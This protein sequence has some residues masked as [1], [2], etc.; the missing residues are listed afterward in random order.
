[1]STLSNVLIL[2]AP[3]LPGHYIVFVLPAKCLQVMHLWQKELA[4]LFRR[5]PNLITYQREPR[6]LMGHTHKGFRLLQES[7]DPLYTASVL[8]G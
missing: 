4:Y 8:S 2:G 3:A 1:M 6:M 5:V 7:S